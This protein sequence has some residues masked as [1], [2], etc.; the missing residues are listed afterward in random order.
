MTIHPRTRL[1]ALVG[2]I[3][4]A[5]LAL[6]PAQAASAHDN[7]LEA[8]PAAGETVTE[9]DT[10]ALTFSA[11]LIDFGQASYA[12]VQGPDGLYYET[13]CSTID[14][15]V[16]TTPVALGEA[17]TYSVVWNA[18]SSDGHPISASYE[19]TY[20]PAEGAEP[21]L[22]WDQPACRNED[23]RVQPGAAPEPSQ[24]PEPTADVS[25]SAPAP[26]PS[27]SEDAAPESEGEG[28]AVAGVIGACVLLVAAFIGGLLALRAKSRRRR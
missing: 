14:M 5:A 10:V 27:S 6:V 9:L 20:A 3:A 22:G 12:Q 18:V 25:E 19:F 11:E 24:E 23:T 17:G 7:L 8:S 2:V 28:L 1:G 16:L 21:G 13:S 15:N 4:V 26:Q